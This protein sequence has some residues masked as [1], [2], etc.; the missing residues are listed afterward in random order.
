MTGTPFAILTPPLGATSGWGATLNSNLADVQD[1]VVAHEAAYGVLVDTFAGSTDDAKLSAAMSYAAAQTRPPALLL[2]SRAH[3]FSGGPYAYYNGMRI[4]GSLGTTEREFASTGPQCVATIG[5][6]AFLSVPSGGAQNIWISGIQF[7]A[8][9][10]SVNFQTPVT[11]LANGP[12]LQ[13]VDYRSLAWVGFASVMQARHLRVGIERMYCNVGT[14]T[15]FQLAGSDNTYWTEGK[16]FLSS[17]TLTASQYYLYFTHMS[18]TRVG[19][20]YIT[21][22][23]ATAVRIDGSYG[24]LQFHGTIF[25]GTGRTSTT[26]CQGSAVLI[27]GGQGMVFDSCWFFNNCVNPSSTGRSPVDKGQAMVRGSATEVLF[28]NC[29][30]GGGGAQTIYTPSGTPAIYAAT[31]AAGVKVSNPIAPYGGTKLLQH[32][33]SGIIAKYGA[34]DWTLSVA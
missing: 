23:V 21:P 30:F 31:G 2:A 4:V 14:G 24:D 10:G 19:A 26:A 33:T 17:T 7:R 1:R 16:S 25:D 8:A 13:D 27:T 5:G 34:D 18:R 29:S 11:D 20:V 9:S 15:Q 32:G 28:N 22:Q 6:S 3:S 12:I